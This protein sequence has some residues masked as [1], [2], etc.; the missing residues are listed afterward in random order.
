M[1]LQMWL[2]HIFF[3]PTGKTSC[4]MSTDDIFPPRWRTTTLTTSCC[5]APAATPPPM[6]T[7]ASWSSSWLKSSPPL[8]AAR[9]EFACMRTRTDGGCVRQ[10]GLCSPQ[11]TDCRSSDEK[12]YRLWSRVSSTQTRSRSWRTRRCSR[13]PVWRRGEQLGLWDYRFKFKQ[14]KII[15]L[16]SVSFISMWLFVPTSIWNKYFLS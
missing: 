14:N 8:R 16:F 1:T 3:A 5:S 12:T 13:P 6:C 11:G 4:H 7:T 15:L 10:P 9:R 2:F